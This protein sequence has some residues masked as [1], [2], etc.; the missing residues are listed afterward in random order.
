MCRGIEEYGTGGVRL[1]WV[2]SF[3]L[4]KISSYH[5]MRSRIS[6]SLLQEFRKESFSFENNPRSLMYLPTS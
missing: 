4:D 5:L 6:P 3:P 1:A 2:Y